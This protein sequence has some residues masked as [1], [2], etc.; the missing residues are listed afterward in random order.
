M[1]AALHEVVAGGLYVVYPVALPYV[2]FPKVLADP[3]TVVVA[4][5]GEVKDLVAV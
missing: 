1:R 5:P 3:V 2:V 4:D